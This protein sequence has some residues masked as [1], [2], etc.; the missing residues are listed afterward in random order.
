MISGKDS[1]FSGLTERNSLDKSFS[2][3]LRKAVVGIAGCGGLGSNAAMALTRAG[4]GKLILT[5]FDNVALS[6]LNRQFFFVDDIGK[7]KVEALKNNLRKINPYI[8]ID[9][10]I[11]KIIPDNIEELFSLADII[12]EAFDDEK[13]KSMIINAFLDKKSFLSKYLVCASGLGGI[14]SA[15]LI[16]TIKYSDRIYVSGDFVSTVCDGYGVVAPRVCLASA[17]EANMVIRLITGEKEP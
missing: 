7:P 13:E 5:D 8:D 17:H 14:G 11:K 10:H 16:K 1:F 4:V 12:V 2:E 9:S 15:N 3:K 6:N